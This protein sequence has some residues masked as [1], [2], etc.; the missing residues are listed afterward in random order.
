MLIVP[1][2]GPAL[3]YSVNA[4]ALR[5]FSRVKLLEAFKAAG[6]EDLSEDLT[7]SITNY[8]ESL[9]LAE[10]G[11]LAGSIQIAGTDEASQLPFFVTAC[12]YTLIGEELYAASAYLAREPLLLGAL[13]AQDVLKGLAM[14]WLLIG[15]ILISISGSWSFLREWISVRM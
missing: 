4:A 1:L 9:I 13:K 5:T 15:A 11:N 10:T 6:K 14:L 7:N 3:F 2:A 8:A 12:D